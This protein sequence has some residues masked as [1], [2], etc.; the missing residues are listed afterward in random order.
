MG[1]SAFNGSCSENSI[2]TSSKRPSNINHVRSCKH[3]DSKTRRNVEPPRTTPDTERGLTHSP[4]FNGPLYERMSE[5]LHLGGM[6]KRTHEGCLRAVRQLAD[7]C[8][9]TPDQMRIKDVKSLPEVLTIEQVHQII[10][11]CTTQRKSDRSP[12]PTSSLA[13]WACRAFAPGPA[14]GTRTFDRTSPGAEA[15]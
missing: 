11:A 13:S 2:M 12:A 1:R 8:Q 7:F 9:R 6:S 5:D 3:L 10:D 14:C 15:R 4:Y